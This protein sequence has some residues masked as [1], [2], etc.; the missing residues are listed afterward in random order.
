MTFFYSAVIVVTFSMGRTERTNKGRQMKTISFTRARCFMTC[1][2][3]YAW[4]YVHGIKAVEDAQPLYF[5][6]AMHAALEAWYKYDSA[7]I[8]QD[9]LK[10][11]GLSEQD[12]TKAVVLL[13]KYVEKY[14][15]EPFEIID[16]EKDIA[17]PLRNP[18]TRRKSRTWGLSGRV[19]GLVRT[20]DGLFIFEHKTAAAIDSAYLAR[21]T[22]DL[23][24]ATYAAALERQI[25]EPIVGA[26]YNIIKKP[27]H[28]MRKG[29]TDA[30]F[31]QRRAELL[32]KSKT[33]KTTAK[34]K[35]PETADEFAARLSAEID[36]SF[37]VREIVR[38][39]PDIIADGER[40]LWNIAKDIQKGAI[41]RNTSAC[42][43][44]GRCPYL[45]LCRNRGDLEKCGDLYTIE[46]RR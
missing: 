20:S 34:K 24:I 25:G 23:Q 33:G 15:S 45:E 37:F 12:E 11:A 26:I 27:M 9:A 46:E 14:A 10:N 5:G 35:E 4:Q 17:A 7:E 1:R 18:D 31:E 38:F 39:S 6:R 30:E 29:E 22:I 28:Q 13:R 43:G 16:I 44:I 8:A 36:D 2:Q 42:N 19:D 41:Y 3:R 40:D 32:A 21:V